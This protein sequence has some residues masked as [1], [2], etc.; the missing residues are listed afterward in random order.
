VDRLEEVWEAAAPSTPHI[1]GKTERIVSNG[2]HLAVVA[3]DGERA[4]PTEARAGEHDV[5]ISGFQRIAGVAEL[6]PHGQFSKWVGDHDIVVFRYDGEIKALS[7]V[8]PHFGGP[9][10]YHQMKDGVFTCLWHNYRFE[11]ASGR[12]LNN[13]NLCL[14]E[15]QVR[16]VDGSIWVRLVENAED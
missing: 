10:G 5:S 8:C 16:V 11:A 1:A 2:G 13:K 15:Y 12:C 3:P 4:E 6:N 9:V 14:R 7:N